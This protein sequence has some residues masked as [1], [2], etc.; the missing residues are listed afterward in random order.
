MRKKWIWF[1]SG[2]EVVPWFSQIYET[3]LDCANASWWCLCVLVTPDLWGPFL[4]S[5][6]EFAFQFPLLVS[7]LPA[8][9]LWKGS[10]ILV[11]PQLPRTALALGRIQEQ[12]Y[13]RLCS[14][15]ARLISGETD[16][17]LWPAR[18]PGMFGPVSQPF[19]HAVMKGEGHSPGSCLAANTGPCLHTRSEK[20][21]PTKEQGRL[22]ML[23]P[24][25]HSCRDGRRTSRK[26][27]DSSLPYFC[28]VAPVLRWARK[29]TP[30]QN[31]LKMY[32]MSWTGGLHRDPKAT[33]PTR[34]HLYPSCKPW[35]PQ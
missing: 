35:W 22:G 29:Q 21:Q 34:L 16:L 25:L 5:E 18:T 24:L 14:V 8:L 13:Y 7:L 4:H 23:T 31:H 27:W 15:G 1:I 19:L 20:R 9:Q 12:G 33:V 3:S 30:I 28:S 26:P 17:C 2:A 32:H 6:K 11:P 10:C